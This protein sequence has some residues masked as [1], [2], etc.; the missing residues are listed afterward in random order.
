MSALS[1]LVLC[2]EALPPAK[3]LPY[4]LRSSPWQVRLVIQRRAWRPENSLECLRALVVSGDPLL[5]PPVASAS[6]AALG[7]EFQ[8]LLAVDS[9]TS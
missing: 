5:S 3:P 4:F 1:V 7:P 8:I 2:A 9:K 6:V